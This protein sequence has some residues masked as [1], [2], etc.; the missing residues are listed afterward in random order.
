MARTTRCPRC[1][2]HVFDILGHIAIKH[3][4]DLGRVET[5]QEPTPTCPKCGREASLELRPDN[6]HRF[7]ICATCDQCWTLA[8]DGAAWE[9]VE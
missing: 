9:L 7:R 5:I 4:V 8:S 1:K 3:A 6:G 2:T